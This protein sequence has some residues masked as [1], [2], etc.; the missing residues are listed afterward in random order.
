MKQHWQEQKYQ[1]KS[2]MIQIFICNF[3][4]F[5]YFLLNKL[6]NFPLSNRSSSFLAPGMS[7]SVSFFRYLIAP[8]EIISFL[9]FLLGE[10][11]PRQETAYFF[12]VFWVLESSNWTRFGTLVSSILTSI[13]F[14]DRTIRL[15]MA[16]AATS[17]S[18]CFSLKHL[19]KKRDVSQYRQLQSVTHNHHL[20]KA[21]STAEHCRVLQSHVLF[22]LT[23]TNCN[24]WKDK[25]AF[26]LPTTLPDSTTL[27]RGGTILS[28][29][30][31][32]HWCI[33]YLIT[34]F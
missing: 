29:L 23:F 34:L 9:H 15:E 22:M 27:M 12:A 32:M 13:W 26:Y 10:C 5:L 2:F 4:W 28:L 6:L 20:D 16:W 25:V 21:Q 1:G 24:L 14:W 7:I 17:S 18:I 30:F 31:R 33:L 3:Q 8:Y 11:D 19:Y